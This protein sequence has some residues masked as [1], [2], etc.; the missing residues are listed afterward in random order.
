MIGSDHTSLRA[1]D[2]E[3]L[4][5]ELLRRHAAAAAS[6]ASIAIQPTI[7]KPEPAQRRL[8]DPYVEIVEEP[9][10]RGLRFRYKCEGRS[11][12]SLPGENSTNEQKTFPTIKVLF[13]NLYCSRS[14]KAIAVLDIFCIRCNIRCCFCTVMFYHHLRL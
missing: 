12:G 7:I 4:R 9:K 5:A 11:A 3:T 1:V 13:H 10:A 8:P 2:I 6:G 14:A